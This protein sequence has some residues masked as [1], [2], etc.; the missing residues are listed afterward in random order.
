MRVLN[1]KDLSKIADPKD[2][3]RLTAKPESKP[4]PQLVAL[5]RLTKTIEGMQSKQQTILSDVLA[6][7][8]DK[9]DEREIA[10]L[11]E[12]GETI[13]SSMKSQTDQMA[14]ALAEI[15]GDTSQSDATGRLTQAVAMLASESNRASVEAFAKLDELIL[16][17][18]SVQ[19]REPIVNIDNP[20]TVEMPKP[21]KQYRVDVVR[22]PQGPIDHAIITRQ[23]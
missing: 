23:P 13:V 17:I 14:S 19:E 5:E 16:K 9:G 2:M 21:A 3:Q 20:V 22:T 18:G 12:L 6:A 11:K 4:D 8:K 15:K 7:L 10:A 1:T